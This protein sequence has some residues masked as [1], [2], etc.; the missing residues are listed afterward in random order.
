MTRRL[1]QIGHDL[2]SLHASAQILL[3]AASAASQEHLSLLEYLFHNNA[4][5][6]SRIW[7]EV[8]AFVHKLAMRN[9]D[10]KVAA[11]K[12]D[13]TLHRVLGRCRGG[14]SCWVLDCNLCSTLRFALLTTLGEKDET[15]LIQIVASSR[16]IRATFGDAH[17][18]RAG[19]QEISR[20]L[21]RLE[22]IIFASGALLQATH[23]SYLD[24][25]T[26]D[27]HPQRWLSGKE[28]EACL[29][30]L[31]RMVDLVKVDTPEKTVVQSEG[32]DH[33]DE[34]C[35]LP[36]EDKINEVI[37]LFKLERS[38][39]NSL[40]LAADFGKSRA[41]H[42]QI[43]IVTP[44]TVPDVNQDACA[45][46]GASSTDRVER[47]QRLDVVQDTDDR[48]SGHSRPR[49]EIDVLFIGRT[50]AG[51]SSLINMVRGIPDHSE[52]AAKVSHDA[53][54]CTAHTDTYS[55]S[56][57][58]GVR[59]RLWDTPGLDHL[60]ASHYVTRLVDRIR[61][62]PA[63]QQARPTEVTR[64]RNTTPKPIIL[65]WCIDVMMPDI[66]SQLGGKDGVNI[67]SSSWGYP[68]FP[69]SGSGDTAVDLR[70]STW[71]IPRLS[72]TSS[73]SLLETLSLSQTSI[74]SQ[75]HKAAAD[76]I[77]AVG[78]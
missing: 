61:H 49:L 40:L 71:K 50:G 17:T 20:V 59:C 38:R 67:S 64:D 63:S 62:Q 39:F 74:N 69:Y 77:R 66:L 4:P 43:P 15:T 47:T 25:P 73:P 24:N 76:N 1:V 41:D 53:R 30:I 27:R 21:R 56:L 34:Q 57:E 10:I 8:P 78:K 42:Q 16:K 45:Q 35:R 75:G 22:K 13:T 9:V 44:V 28:L 60:A 2:S 3:L 18:K 48:S 7:Q 23:K 31:Q 70:L 29:E 12:G 32:G 72:D 46:V 6:P 65:V 11:A 54:P 33:H 36:S 55:S 68:I 37:A 52:A 58:A 51:K 5:M 14:S 26:L 19:D